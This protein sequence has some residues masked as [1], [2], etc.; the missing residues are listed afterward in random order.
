MKTTSGN[1]S[2][3]QTV[4][5]SY[6]KKILFLTSFTNNSSTGPAPVHHEMISC[7]SD[8][9]N[10]DPPTII[11]MGSVGPIFLPILSYLQDT[12]SLALEDRG[13]PIVQVTEPK[14][15][16][17][18]ITMM[19]CERLQPQNNFTYTVDSNMDKT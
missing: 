7:I 4:G 9:G 18:D 13:Q 8:L 12:P 2:Q 3:Q 19:S 5:S 11:N 17:C 14:L 15:S 10:D 1:F 16:L 6:I